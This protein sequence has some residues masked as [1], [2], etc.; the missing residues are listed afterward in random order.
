MR[1]SEAGSAPIRRVLHLD[2]TT[3]GQ[4]ASVLIDCVEGGASVSFMHPLAPDKAEAFW[5]AL[6]GDVA[7]GARILLVGEDATGI[8]GTVQVV[9]AQPENQPH[10][11]DVAK[12]LV[13]RRGP[14]AW[15]RRSADA[16]GEKRPRGRPARRCSSSTR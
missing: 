7:S 1:A 9:L 6:D 12:M 4:L 13:H 2:D 10:R 15:Y 14:R 5:R 16:R 3:I 11:A 8:V